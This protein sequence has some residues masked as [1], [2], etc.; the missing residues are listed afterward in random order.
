MNLE[1]YTGKA[2]N[3]YEY[4]GCH[5]DEHGAWFRVFAPAAK[6]ITVIG[7]FNGWNDAPM[8]KVYDGNFWECYIEGVKPGD[9]YKYRIFRQDGQVVEH[10]K[11]SKCS[12]FMIN[13]TSTN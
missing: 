6:G 13:I 1:F 12:I 4:L 8:H 3:A 11:I 9:M 2:L 5:V 7:S 10:C